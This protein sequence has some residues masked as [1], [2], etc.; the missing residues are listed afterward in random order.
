MD[1]W[2]KMKDNLEEVKELIEEHEANN[3]TYIELNELTEDCN[4]EIMMLYLAICNYLKV[5]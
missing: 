1:Y 4:S 3:I 5:Y 2:Y